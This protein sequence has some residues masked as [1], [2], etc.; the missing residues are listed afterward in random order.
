MNES[1]GPVKIDAH[2]CSTVEP[3]G[4]GR[5][6][7]YTFLLQASLSGMCALA[8]DLD[9]FPKLVINLDR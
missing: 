9:L 1:E 8:T 5:M 3:T 2:A 6:A 4:P 7:I